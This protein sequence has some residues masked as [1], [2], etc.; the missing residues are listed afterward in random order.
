MGKETR[1]LALDQSSKVTGWAIFNNGVL[2]KHGKFSFTDLDMITRIIK[3][4]NSVDKLIKDEN[5]TNVALEE[6]QMQKNTNNVVTF[7]VLA[8]VQAAILILC[9]ENAIP[10]EVV[11]SSTWKS[12]CGVKGKARLE[13]KQNAQK[14]VLEEFG[15]KAI[16][17]TV[18]AICI[19]YSVSESDRGKIEFGQ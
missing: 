6:I 14:F 8:Q 4:K 1:L 2:E 7:K 17:D 18:D 11:A 15:V 13:Q 10:Y 12:T 16:Q 3:L 5:I 19:G 9:N